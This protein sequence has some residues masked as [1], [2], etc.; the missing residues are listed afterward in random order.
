MA[1]KY[2]NESIIQTTLDIFKTLINCE[3]VEFLEER[4]FADALLGFI[5]RIPEKGPLLVAADTEERIVEVCFAIASNLRLRPNL[6]STWFRP[7]VMG[8]GRA[9][10][11]HTK[12]DKDVFP[13]LYLTLDYVHHDGRVGDFARTGVLYIIESAT[14]SEPLERWLVESDLATLM[15]S[16]LGALYCQL[17]FYRGLHA[18]NIILLRHASTEDSA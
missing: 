13:L 3:E 2:H 8:E 7:T 16:G 18:F 9:F 12:E 5:R 4:T 14:H 6:L 11:P 17:S 10:G 1:S 15:A